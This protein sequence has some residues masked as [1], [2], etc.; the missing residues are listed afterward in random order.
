MTTILFGIELYNSFDDQKIYQNII[1][2][3]Q[4]E[5]DNQDG[6]IWDKQNE[7][8]FYGILLFRNQYQVSITPDNMKSAINLAEA[9]YKQLNEIMMPFLSPEVQE[10][11]KSE[12]AKIIAF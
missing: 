9:R 11:V 12:E 2:N 1:N 7:T 10:W 4:D 8:I 6:L 3:F 5:N